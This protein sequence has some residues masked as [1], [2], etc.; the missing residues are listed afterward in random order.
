MEIDGQ[1]QIGLS[2]KDNPAQNRFWSHLVKQI[3]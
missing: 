1:E 2:N 3:V